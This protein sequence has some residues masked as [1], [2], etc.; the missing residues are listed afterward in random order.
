MLT[1]KLQAL[2]ID[3]NKVIALD[4]TAAEHYQHAMD[5]GDHIEM[6]IPAFELF[7][8]VIGNTHKA[9]TQLYSVIS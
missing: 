7:T 4:S 8:T 3:P 2:S 5:I 1:L 6:Y 9:K